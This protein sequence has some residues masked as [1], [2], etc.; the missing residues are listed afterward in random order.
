MVDIV[1]APSSPPPPQA[2]PP[3]HTFAPHGQPEQAAWQRD[4]NV[5]SRDDPATNGQ[6]ELCAE[7]ALDNIRRRNF[8]KVSASGPAAASIL[9]SRGA[10][11]HGS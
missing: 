3:L 1:V 10:G 11:A 5:T 2:P 6:A 4:I 7:E 8:P 9:T